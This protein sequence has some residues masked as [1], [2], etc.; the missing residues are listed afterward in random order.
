M[1]SVI[2]AV[3]PDMAEMLEYMCKLEG[4][5]SACQVTALCQWSLVTLCTETSL[6][7]RSRKI[8]ITFLESVA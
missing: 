2:P 5:W 4:E 7:E 8:M 3:F 1:T 6:I